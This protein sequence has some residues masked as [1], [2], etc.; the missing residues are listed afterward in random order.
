MKSL[1]IFA[2]ISFSI[3]GA[4]DY[5]KIANNGA[6]LPGSAYLGNHS[7]D[8][9]CTHDSSTGL[10][11]EVKTAD[12]NLRDGTWTYSYS[13]SPNQPAASDAC[14]DQTACNIEKFMQKV[15]TQGLCNN[16]N[17][18]LPTLDE[19]KSIVYCSDGKETNGECTKRSQKPQINIAYFPHLHP[20]KYYWTT[21]PAKFFPGQ[22]AIHSFYDG[23]TYKSNEQG[24]SLPI[25]LVSTSK[26]AS[27][28]PEVSAETPKILEPPLKSEPV[29]TVSIPNETKVT[30]PNIP[31]PNEANE[32]LDW[33]QLINVSAAGTYNVVCPKEHPHIVMGGAT[34]RHGQ[35]LSESKPDSRGTEYPNQWFAECFI[36]NQ[37]VSAKPTYVYGWCR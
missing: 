17:W 12:Q 21:T 8:W 6:V 4:A 32:A 20:F 22:Q 35:M 33:S 11:W 5:Y 23:F 36:P 37:G 16:K 1:V 2:L 28:K 19:I 10:T 9:A 31:S 15:N 7:E 18:R 24:S 27:L 14:F 29:T 26:P 30:T 3:N 13:T 25:I 34:C